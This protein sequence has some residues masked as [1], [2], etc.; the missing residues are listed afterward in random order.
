[1]VPWCD[2]G[3]NLLYPDPKKPING[4]RHAPALPLA[5]IAARPAPPVTVPK[6]PYLAHVQER[7]A[8]NRSVKVAEA[9]MKAAEERA[10]WCRNEAE[11]EKDDTIRALLV[12]GAE[13]AKAEAEELRKSVAEGRA[14]SEKLTREIGKLPKTTRKQRRAAERGR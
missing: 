12:D 6:D 10:R 2:S 8:V 4:R 11:G 14:L 7:D 9:A 5:S 3:A 13:K 1:M